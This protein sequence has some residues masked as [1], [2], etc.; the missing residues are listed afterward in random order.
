MGRP[1]GGC[2]VVNSIVVFRFYRV[3]QQVRTMATEKQRKF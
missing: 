2:L 3:A 1:S